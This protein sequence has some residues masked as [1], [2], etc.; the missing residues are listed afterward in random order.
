MGYHETCDPTSASALQA[1]KTFDEKRIRLI[2]KIVGGVLHCGDVRTGSPDKDWT[3]GPVRVSLDPDASHGIRIEP[4]EHRAFIISKLKTGIMGLSIEDSLV[5]RGNYSEVQRLPRDDHD[6]D[7]EPDIKD[8]PEQKP[9]FVTTAWREN[10]Q[11]P[12]SEWLVKGVIPRRGTGM[13][14]GQSMVFKS[15]V[16]M[17]LGFCAATGQK[18]AGR[19]VE[20]VGVVYVVAEGAGGFK[21][22]KAGIIKKWPKFKDVGFDAIYGA[23]NLGT[24]DGDLLALIASIEAAGIR[25]GLVIIDTA[26]KVLAGADE[27]GSGM[28]SLL[29]NMDAMAEHFGC[30]VMTVHHVGHSDGAQKRPRGSSAIR[31]ALDVEILA[32]RDEGEMCTRLTVQKTKESEAGIVLM[33][34]LERIVISHDEDGDEISTSVVSEVTEGVERPAAK[35]KSVAGSI[36]IFKTA[37]TE[38]LANHG[39]VS[40]SGVKVVTKKIVREEY[41]RLLPGAP[42]T[43]SRTFR[44]DLTKVAEKGLVDHDKVNLWL[45]A[46]SS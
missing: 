10:E 6:A 31:P 42:E 23:P 3:Y 17:H 12:N 27:N 7:S 29:G 37:L 4:A 30:F 9:Q 33:A 21:K 38:A 18:L 28:A 44:R 8:H 5:L 36:D 19:K 43:V 13:L 24:T 41:G 22:R 11:S 14:F 39:A 16:A 2:H 25:P 34:S 46:H 26:S 35:G 40:S 15:F 20:R 32:E 1:T 45:C